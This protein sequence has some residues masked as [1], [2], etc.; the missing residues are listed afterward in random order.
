MKPTIGLVPTM[1]RLGL[2][3]NR[4]EIDYFGPPA[5]RGHARSST[6]TTWSY[7]PHES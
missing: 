7:W 2:L 5:R 1:L 3:A 6:P 4:G